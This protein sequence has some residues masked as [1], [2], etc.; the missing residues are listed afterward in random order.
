VRGGQ[1]SQD[2]LPGRTGAHPVTNLG[3]ERFTE[4]RTALINETTGKAPR[5]FGAL[6]NGV[7]SGKFEPGVGALVH[8]HLTPGHDINRLMEDTTKLRKLLKD[9]RRAE[10][11]AAMEHDRVRAT[12]RGGGGGGILSW[13]L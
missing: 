11:I 7:L 12:D 3:P 9:L 8:C 4:W 1:F 5:L 13:H 10:L 2:L 6:E